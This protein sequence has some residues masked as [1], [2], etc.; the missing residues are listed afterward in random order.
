MRR[1]IARQHQAGHRAPAGEGARHA[2]DEVALPQVATEA[3]QR[4]RIEI[5]ARR[6]LFLAPGAMAIGKIAGG[7]GVEPDRILQDRSADPLR[8]ELTELETEARADAA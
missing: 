5:R 7:L 6:E 8:R 1:V 4:C 2:E 3:F